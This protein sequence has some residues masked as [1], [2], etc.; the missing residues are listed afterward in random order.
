[1]LFSAVLALH[2]G[3]GTVGLLSGAAAMTVR[4]GSRNH[5]LVGNVFVISMLGL[6]TSAV[7][8]ATV[9][10]QMPNVLGGTFTFYLVATAWLTAHRRDERT[11]ISDWAGLLLVLAL[12]LAYFTYGL[13]AAQSPSGMKDGYR[14]GLYFFSGFLAMLAAAGDVRVLIRGGIYGTQRLVRHI[15]RMCWGLFVASGSIFLARPHLFPVLLRKAGVLGVLGFLPLILMI[16]WLIR[17][18]LSKAYKT[19]PPQHAGTI[20]APQASLI[21]IAHK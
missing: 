15:W 16:F 1:M 19:K 6:A 21:A 9:K 13:E 10:H 20:Y 12:M 11:D 4:K 14:P 7:Y 17:V 8:M 3:C 2:I 18:R 5:R